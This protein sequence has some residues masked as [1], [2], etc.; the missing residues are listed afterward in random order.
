[1]ME[2]KCEGNSGRETEERKK[3]LS[4]SLYGKRTTYREPKPFVKPGKEEK[5]GKI[6]GR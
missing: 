1:L 2:E 4:T 5:M 6:L 3:V